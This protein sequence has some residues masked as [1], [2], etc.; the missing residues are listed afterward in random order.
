MELVSASQITLYREC[1][2]KW[3]W[4][5][6]AKLK[7]PQH[8]AAALGTEVD[9]T[10]LQ[11]YLKEGR[12][13]DLSRESGLIA[14]S[15][16]H[17]LPEPKS[18]SLE[19]QKH[20]VMPSPTGAFGF[21][22]YIDLW[23]PKGG[24]PGIAEGENVPAV[25]DFK[26]SKNFR[27]AKTKTGLA[28]DVQAQ[29]YATWAMFET[30]SRVVDLVWTYFRTKDKRESKRT[31]LRVLGS[32]VAQQ[33]TAINDTAVEMYAARKS[34]TDPKELK[35]HTWMCGEFLGCPY[36]N[37]CNLSPKEMAEGQLLKL[38]MDMEE[39]QMTQ[40]ADTASLM[41]RLKKQQE[42]PV[43][44]SP[45]S[46]ANGHTDKPVG[47]A[48]GYELS[49]KQLDGQAA[50]DAGVAKVEMVGINPPESLLPP[51][52][53][54][55]VASAG[56]VEPAVAIEKAKRGR[57]AGSKNA[58]KDGAE[59]LSAGINLS[60][61]EFRKEAFVEFTKTVGNAFLKLSTQLEVS[62]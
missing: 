60:E 8:P 37:M 17:F 32:E 19:V 38:A 24:V 22:G 35:A 30:G 5:Y 51:A 23:L 25:V 6:I 14:Q 20:F 44:Q 16:I 41:S 13:L 10:Q 42:A 18:C 58:T 57:P 29:L 50:A 26:T 2:R 1:P 28:I 4:R 36:Q 48:S 27:Y 3:G 45:V 56:L 62:K 47:G 39:I 52:P 7:T 43:Q 12:D 33:F 49:E 31:H 21:Q 53:P 11:P 59:L 54:V 9:D 15:G 34:V 40:S 61:L 55:G 46:I